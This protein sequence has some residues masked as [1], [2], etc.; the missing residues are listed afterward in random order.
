ME[1][2]KQIAVPKMAE[3]EFR[4]RAPDDAVLGDSLPVA[5]ERESAVTELEKGRALLKTGELDSAISVLTNAIR[6]GPQ[7]AKRDQPR[8]CLYEER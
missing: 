7:L 8:S 6:L 4:F 5:G 3:N 2:Y 1:I